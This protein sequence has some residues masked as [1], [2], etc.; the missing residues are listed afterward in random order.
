M[1]VE[2]R[3][4]T[5]ARGP[6]FYIGAGALLLA[7][8]VEA[9]SVVGRHIGVPLLGAIEIIQAAI[10]LTA[11]AAMVATTI[12]SAHARVTLLIDRAG[13]AA[14]GTLQRLS[15]L[16]SIVF[17]A[18]LAAGS[19]W[20]TVDTWGEFEQSELLHIPFRP[21]RVISFVAAAA[22]AVLFLRELFRRTS[23]QR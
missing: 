13:P 19:L 18:G 10:L 4:R 3:G 12:G 6:L 22:I 16:L 14:R 1:K 17:F 23:E 5:E 8:A 11:T 7:M 21:L 20:L 15:A 2:G 9:V